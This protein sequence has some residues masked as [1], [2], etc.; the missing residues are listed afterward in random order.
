[1]FDRAKGLEREVRRWVKRDPEFSK[2][3]T[4]TPYIRLLFV[5][6]IWRDQSPWLGMQ[7]SEIR[8]IFKEPQN[9]FIA[10]P[11]NSV[12]PTHRGF[13]ARQTLGNDPSRLTLTW[14]LSRSLTSEVIIPLNFH[15]GQLWEIRNHLPE[16][17]HSNSFINE[18][19]LQ[20]FDTASIVDLNLLFHVIAGIANKYESILEKSGWNQGFSFKARILNCWRVVPFLDT[21]VFIADVRTHGAFMSLTS[22]MTVPPGS[23]VSS[24]SFLDRDLSASSDA[25]AR[26]ISTA[27]GMF[28]RIA[29]AFGIPMADDNGK[30][31]DITG[32]LDAGKRALELQ[33]ARNAEH[34]DD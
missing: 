18:L 20:G 32:V 27:I 34:E 28:L 29:Q 1:L 19:E 12:H 17:K 6:D 24:F 13:I 4:E 26:C 33:A 3:E 2:A 11:F 10:L 5:P 14:R 23:D 22:N 30:P 9:E 7:L 8:E 15:K 25:H 16:Y 31:L 21:E